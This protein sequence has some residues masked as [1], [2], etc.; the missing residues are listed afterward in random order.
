MAEYSGVTKASQCGCSVGFLFNDRSFACVNFSEPN[1]SGQTVTQSEDNNEVVICLL[2]RAGGDGGG[3]FLRSNC[4]FI[5]AQ[6]RRRLDR[7]T[8]CEVLKRWSQKTK[9]QL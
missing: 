6:K 4:C 7:I 8:T 3:A 1:F 9:N 5:S 2:T